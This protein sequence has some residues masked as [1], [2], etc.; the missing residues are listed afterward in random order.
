MLLL[1]LLL[2]ARLGTSV[3]W[4]RCADR[5]VGEVNREANMS[6]REH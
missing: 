2:Q 4:G 3:Q 6:S 1:L 5:D